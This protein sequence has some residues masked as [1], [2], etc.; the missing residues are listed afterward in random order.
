MGHHHTLTSDDEVTEA[1]AKLG[2]AQ[3]Q[4]VWTAERVK[5]SISTLGIPV[6]KQNVAFEGVLSS[7]TQNTNAETVLTWNDSMGDPLLIHNDGDARVECIAAREFNFYFNVQVTTVAPGGKAVFALVFDHFD[8]IGSLLFSYKIAAGACMP[9][10]Q[11]AAGIAAGYLTLVLAA[12]ESVECRTTVIVNQSPLAENFAD[13]S[14]SYMRII[15]RVYSN[16]AAELP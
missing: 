9:N 10:P 14:L 16:V 11:L 15:E 3:D 1:E 2:Q 12:G 6:P 7:A 5:D 4:K 13:D 8:D